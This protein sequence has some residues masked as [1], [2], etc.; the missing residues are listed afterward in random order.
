MNNAELEKLLKIARVP[1]RTRDFWEQFPNRV[2][3][4][5]HWRARRV[6]AGAAAERSRKRAIVAWGMGL[7][8]ACVLLGF[9][10]GFWRGRE[11]GVTAAQLA[12]AQKY[13]REIE[14]LFPNQVQAIVLDDSGP[15]VVVADQPDVPNAAPIYVRVVGPHGSQRFITFS[16]QQIRLNGEACDVLLDA[17]GHVLLI[18]TKTVWSSADANARVGGYR[19]AAR[20]LGISS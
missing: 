3:T 5:L 10:V 12:V 6:E 20:P 17:A 15:R 14:A 11:T 8:T 19:F 4:A 16:G 13:F 7:A 18:G 1:E 2:S 9:V